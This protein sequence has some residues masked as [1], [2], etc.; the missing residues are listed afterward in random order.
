MVANGQDRE[1]NGRFASGNSGGPGR[2]RKRPPLG[3]V[4]LRDLAVEPTGPELFVTAMA[5]RDRDGWLADIDSTFTK[6]V[7]TRVRTLLY[8]SD[9]AR[10]EIIRRLR[11]LPV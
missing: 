3:D 11:D 4:T 7:A 1:G 5:L 2:P 8:L 9:M 10:T 6:D